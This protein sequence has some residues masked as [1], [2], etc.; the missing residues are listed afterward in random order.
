M[1]EYASHDS[2]ILDV[3][4]SP[5]TALLYKKGYKNLTTLGFPI[6]RTHLDKIVEIPRR[7]PH[8]IFDLNNCKQ[9]KEWVKLPKFDL[10]I[11]AEVLEH[12]YVHP[13]YVFKF[14]KS[15]LKSGGYL[16]IQTPNAV[17]I[18][19]RIKMILGLHPYEEIRKGDDPGHFREYTKKEIIKY[20]KNVGLELVMHEYKNYFGVKGFTNL[21][22]ILTSFYPPFRQGQTF[23]FK[24]R[25][26]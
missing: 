9:P 13:E 18:G 17:A 12:L 6:S 21:L 14:L 4:R 16:I 11:F 19:K 3:G 1:E 25:D 8:I 20:G 26:Y 22:Y 5:L 2:K 23:I 10:I 7:V 24:K 15:G